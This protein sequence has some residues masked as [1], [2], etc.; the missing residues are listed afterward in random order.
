MFWYCNQDSDCY[1]D[2]GPKIIFCL[3]NEDFFFL[4]CNVILSIFSLLLIIYVFQIVL[5]TKEKKK[6][7]SVVFI[8]K[9]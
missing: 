7:F 1:K 8:K 5:D 3:G 4:A 6:Q 2:I 9:S